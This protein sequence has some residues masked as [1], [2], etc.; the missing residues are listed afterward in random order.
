M[1]GRVPSTE[2]N[3]TEFGRDIDGVL[4]APR[5]ITDDVVEVQT[6][7]SSGYLAGGVWCV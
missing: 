5:L 3:P 2:R 7:T 1:G 6:A 4:E